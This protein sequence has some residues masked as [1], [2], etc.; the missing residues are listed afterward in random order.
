MTCNCG[1][2]I[3]TI[4]AS[5]LLCNVNKGISINQTTLLNNEY[6]LW[7]PLNFQANIFVKRNKMYYNFPTENTEYGT[8]YSKSSKKTSAHCL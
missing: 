5:V 3:T 8:L 1:S 7:N 6:F 2:E 4:N